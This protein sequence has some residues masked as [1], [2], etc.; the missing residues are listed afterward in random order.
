MAWHYNSLSAQY[1]QYMFNVDVETAF[2]QM[3]KSFSLG[4]NFIR[5]RTYQQKIRYLTR[6]SSIEIHIPG[7]RWRFQIL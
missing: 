6:E 7:S 1:P 2:S 5:I 4:V 3:S